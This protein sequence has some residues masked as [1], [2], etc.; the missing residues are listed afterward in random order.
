MHDK[1]VESGL[2]HGPAVVLVELG[3]RR[4]GRED[5]VPGEPQLGELGAP[6]PRVKGW[7]HGVQLARRQRPLAGAGRREQQRVLHVPLLR[8]PEVLVVKLDMKVS[9]DFIITEAF[10]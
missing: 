5:E 10:S 9:K 8:R 1:A 6:E 7:R 3:P 4:H 2:E